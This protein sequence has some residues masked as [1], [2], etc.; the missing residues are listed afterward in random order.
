MVARL[1]QTQDTIAIFGYIHFDNVLEVIEDLNKCISQMKNIIVDLKGIEHSDSSGLALCT[2]L[3][4]EAKVQ[5]KTLEFV[6]VPNFMQNI[7]QVYG[8]DKVLPIKR[9]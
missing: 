4:R 5:D 2:A 6:N 3:M 9:V 8:L 7:L 1:T